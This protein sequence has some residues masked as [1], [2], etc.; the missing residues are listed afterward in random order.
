MYILA[1]ET[2][3]KYGSAAVIGDNGCP[4]VVASE[5]E[6]NHLQD[7]IT[8]SDAAI[9]Q[10][11]I[12]KSDLT[13]IACS[14][15]P[16]SFTGIRIGVTTAR[17][18]AQMLGIP[19]I[20]VSSL[21]SLVKSV[22]NKAKEEKCELI[23]ASI[24]ARRNQ[25]YAAIY[26]AD[27]SVYAEEKQYMIEEVLEI[28]ANSGRKV[29]VTGDGIDAYADIISDKLNNY[30]LADEKLRYQSAKSVAELAIT[31][32]YIESSCEYEK[33]Q[34]NYMRLSEAEQRLAAGTLS[35]KITG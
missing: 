34:P 35:S 14:V 22:E 2:T 8:I 1:L 20:A 28:A 21:R 26:N 18:L 9:K 19:C 16:G 11:G 10:A 13:H 6:M 15:G 12:A 24:N 4:V 3:G 27:G 25:T 5:N 17:T 30:E 33:L 32:E 7:I 29:F 31:G 23:L